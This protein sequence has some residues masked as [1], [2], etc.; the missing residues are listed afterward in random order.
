LLHRQKAIAE[1]ICAAV[2]ANTMACGAPAP[3]TADEASNGT[4][5]PIELPTARAITPATRAPLSKSASYEEALAEPEDVNLSDDRAHL[6]DLQLSNPMRDVLSKCRVPRKAS[7]TIQTAVKNGLAI[8]VTVNV[9]FEKAK[10]AK[11][12]RPQSPVAAK[13]ELK[14]T[15]LIAECL[16]QAVRALEWP[17]S[18]RRDSFTT[19]F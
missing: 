3:K 6:T 16:D 11:A 8:G 13:A 15:S 10:P 19:R 1:V 7:V 9:A 5:A 4:K 2:I 18:P 17:P 12:A 14:A